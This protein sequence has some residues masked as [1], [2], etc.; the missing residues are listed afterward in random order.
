[1]SRGQIIPDIRS[2]G[3]HDRCSSRTIT[4]F[5]CTI[6]LWLISTDRHASSN[7]LP[8]KSRVE[9]TA[10]ISIYPRAFTELVAALFFDWGLDIER[11]FTSSLVA[12]KGQSLV[13]MASELASASSS[14]LVTSNRV[15]D[16]KRCLVLEGLVLSTSCSTRRWSKEELIAFP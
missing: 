9:A 3:P 1:M 7:P 11:A 15:G 4:C 10:P 8:I 6:H 12:S 13:A 5:S 16:L 2:N 14:R